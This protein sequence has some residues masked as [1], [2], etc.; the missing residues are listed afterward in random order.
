MDSKQARYKQPSLSQGERCIGELPLRAQRIRLLIERSLSRLLDT[1][2]QLL[3][4][5][6]NAVGVYS[7]VV[8]AL[9]A[10]AIKKTIGLRVSGEEEELC[11]D[12]AIHGERA[13]DDLARTS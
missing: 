10:M 9:I 5:R 12:L 13:H 1:V 4:R 11:L 3:V 7:L 6:P 8:S 2:K